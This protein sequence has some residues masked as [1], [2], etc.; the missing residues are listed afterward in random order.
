M[1]SWM[2]SL[3]EPGVPSPTWFDIYMAGSNARHI[4]FSLNNLK[5]DISH[6]FPR[7][8]HLLH[9]CNTIESTLSSTHGGIL[10]HELLKKWN[11]GIFFRRA[12]DAAWTYGL[13]IP[14]VG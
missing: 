8:A 9:L 1:I 12:Q 10:P 6:H 2:A 5:T 7:H 11:D 14:V 3:F 4:W 13:R